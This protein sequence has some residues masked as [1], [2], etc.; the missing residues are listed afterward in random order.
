MRDDL[1]SEVVYIISMVLVFI[2]LLI[3]IACFLAFPVKWLWNALMPMLF[4]LQEIT[5]WEALELEILCSLLFK[6]VIPGHKSKTD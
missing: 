5:F 4:N 1:G 3:V 2:I 6:T